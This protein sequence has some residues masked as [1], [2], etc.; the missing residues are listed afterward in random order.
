[1]ALGLGPG[2]IPASTFLIVSVEVL[3]RGT[4]ANPSACDMLT[5][6]LFDLLTDIDKHSSALVS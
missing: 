4:G 5:D 2:S 1:M 6:F 3:I